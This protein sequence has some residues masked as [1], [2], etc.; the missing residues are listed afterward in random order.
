MTILNN[1]STETEECIEATL[2]SQ[3]NFAKSDDEE[4][5]EDKDR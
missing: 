4:K 5:D 3:E 1:L 2:S